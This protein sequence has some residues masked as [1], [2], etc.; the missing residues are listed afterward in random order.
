M[1]K[2][3]VRGARMPS[4]VIYPLPVV[5]EPDLAE[6]G[7][8]Y[9]LRVAGRNGM[10]LPSLL[11]WLGTSSLRAITAESVRVI[12]HATEAQPLWMATHLPVTIRGG[13]NRRIDLLGCRWT[14]RQA[15][16]L[17][18]PQ[19]CRLCLRERASCQ[20]LWDLTGVF[21]CWRH[22]CLL[23]T[24]CRHCQRFIEW[25]RPAVEVCKCGRYLSAPFE[26]A[27]ASI[28]S[29]RAMAW[30]GYLA[31]SLGGADVAKPA[32]GHWPSWM[33]ALSPDGQFA[34]VQAFGL[35]EDA[36]SHVGGLASKVPPEPGTMK[37]VA[38]RALQRIPDAAELDRTCSSVLRG[39]VYEEALERLAAR[40]E[41]DADRLAAQE[42]ID[43]LRGR[44]SQRRPGCTGRFPL[45]QLGLF[46]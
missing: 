40:G 19:I 41:T 7:M 5:L 18:R 9:L 31:W 33:E 29:S 38:E 12:A 44:A 35:R 43:W 15:L 14:I 24:R 39:L 28:E 4:D 34:V 13:R 10:N 32:D 2:S 11:R 25:F 1:V 16:R 26:D 20:A 8:G 22:R 3:S 23:E 46:R 42:L 45:G 30:I 21:A 37:Q 27:P 36:A 17:S 6:S